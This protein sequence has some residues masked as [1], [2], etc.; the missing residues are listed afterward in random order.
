MGQIFGLIKKIFSLYLVRSRVLSPTRHPLVWAVV[1]WAVV[2][3]PLKPG[4]EGFLDRDL[5]VL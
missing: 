3:G 1:D 2:A 5:L 4:I